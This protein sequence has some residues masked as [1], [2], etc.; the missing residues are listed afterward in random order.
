MKKFVA[1]EKRTTFLKVSNFKNSK[2]IDRTS[3]FHSPDF[4]YNQ[5]DKLWVYLTSYQ[6]RTI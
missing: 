6:R 5:R 2:L 1:A 3:G 4:S